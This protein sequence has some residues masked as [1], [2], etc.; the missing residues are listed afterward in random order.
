MDTS[1]SD[2]QQ[3]RWKRGRAAQLRASSGRFITELEMNSTYRGAVEVLN[4]CCHLDE[5]DV[6]N[7]ECIRTFQERTIDGRS[8]FNRLEMSQTSQEIRT[9]VV[10]TYAPPTRRP[11][12]RTKQSRAN[13]FDAYGYRPLKH[14]WKLLCPS[15]FLQ[16]WDCEPL[17][18]PT[19]YLN[20]GEPVRTAW[21]TKGVELIRSQKYKDGEVAA[22][23]GEYHVA[24]THN[25]T[26]KISQALCKYPFL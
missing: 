20:F 21:T 8:W 3:V 4:L 13:D 17:L 7:A 14:P 15:E 6:L 2:N 16:Q 23:P 25:T 10:S 18:T 9:R 19:H 12:V 26:M 1:V 22:K 5:R 24:A 11:N